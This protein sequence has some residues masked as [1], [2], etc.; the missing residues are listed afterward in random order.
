MNE[1]FSMPECGSNVTKQATI[2]II[3]D[4]SNL[5]AQISACVS[6]VIMNLFKINNLAL[7]TVNMCDSKVVLLCYILPEESTKKSLIL[8]RKLLPI[9]V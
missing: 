8:Q 3:A 4:L 6:E 2:T 9:I 1:V 5:Y 7:A